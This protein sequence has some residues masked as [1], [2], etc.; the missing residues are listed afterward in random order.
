MKT[1]I[2]P[3]HPSTQ[4]VFS[5]SPHTTRGESARRFAVSPFPRFSPLLPLLLLATS[6]FAGILDPPIPPLYRTNPSPAALAN[7]LNLTTNGG[8]YRGDGAGLS[9][10][11]ALNIT[12]LGGLVTTTVTWATNQQTGARASGSTANSTFSAWCIPLGV[13]TNP[14]CNLVAAIVPYT[15]T[16][17]STL[18]A[19]VRVQGWF[20]NYNSLWPSNAYCPSFWTNLGEVTKSVGLVAGTTNY[21]RFSFPGYISSASNL[22]LELRSDG[23]FSLQN[24]SGCVLTNEALLARAM[25]QTSKGLDDPAWHE[26]ASALPTYVGWVGFERGTATNTSLAMV[27]DAAG[28]AYT[29]TTSG[30]AGQNVQAALDELATNRASAWTVPS[31]VFSLPATNYA[32]EGIELNLYYDNVI[33]HNY[34]LADYWVSAYASN[35]LARPSYYRLVPTAA[36]VGTMPLTLAVSFATNPVASWN[37]FVRC[38]SVTNGSGLT[39]GVLIIGDSTTAGSE[40]V[41]GLYQDMATNGFKLRF[42]GSQGTAPT[43]HEGRSGWRLSTFYSGSGSPMTN[44]AGAFDFNFYLTN[45]GLSLVSNDW[46]LVNLGINDMFSYTNDASLAATVAAYTNTFTAMA[47][48][49][50]AVVPGIRLGLCVTIP[51]TS[52][53]TGFAANYGATM[54]YERYRRTR[55]LLAESLCSYAWSN[56]VV[57]PIHAALD[58][59]NG[60]PTVTEPLSAHNTNLW[61]HSGNGVH[62]STLGYWQIAD[63]LWAFLKAHA[64]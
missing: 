6:S 57:V 50:Y 22:A 21:V 1:L 55:Y 8:S 18:R 38:V 24:V 35:G 17:P 3:T 31:A 49:I 26:V 63:A 28:L 15:N 23:Y 16:P 34:A 44:G 45:N 36:M 60:F 5:P 41:N 47:S 39:N 56:V 59:V 2:I 43:N 32:A 9:N 12:G 48:N 25:Y 62:P 29:N 30:L 33:R 20:T 46:V 61:T 40:V 64:R 10:L 27:T 51:P 52:D 53:G 7:A 58:T 13:V 54:S 11:S 14:F 19:V 4:V 37:G 42:A